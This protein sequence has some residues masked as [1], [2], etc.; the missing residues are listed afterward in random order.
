MR[1]ARVR[2]GGGGADRGCRAFP[3]YTHPDRALYIF[4]AEDGS[5]SKEIHGWCQDVVYIPTTGS[6]ILVATVN[7]VLYDRLAKGN[8]TR[9]GPEFGRQPQQ[10]P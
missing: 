7:V 1:A 3:E 4:G 2:A 5:L 8:N 9:S 10:T 6:M